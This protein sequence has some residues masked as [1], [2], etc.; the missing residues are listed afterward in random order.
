MRQSS[1]GGKLIRPEPRAK[2][3]V[4]CP[5]NSMVSPELQ[6]FGMVSPELLVPG[7]PVGTSV[8]SVA[9]EQ[10]RAS[11]PHFLDKPRVRPLPTELQTGNSLPVHS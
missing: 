6:E 10:D 3:S 11:V 9:K 5:R 2:S 8:R 4:W 1:H 7:T